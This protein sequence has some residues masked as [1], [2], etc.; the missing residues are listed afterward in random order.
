M[1]LLFVVL[2]LVPE[3]SRGRD[4]ASFSWVVTQLDGSAGSFI[5]FHAS[6]QE[7]RP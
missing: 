3:E 7:V 2:G 4:D 1:K 6:S 5:E